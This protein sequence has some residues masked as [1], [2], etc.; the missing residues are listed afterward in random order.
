MVCG[1]WSSDGDVLIQSPWTRL[2]RL[3]TVGLLNPGL[4][5]FS[6]VVQP[7][8]SGSGSGSGSGGKNKKRNSRSEV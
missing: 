7:V 8:L 4:A 6:I 2:T 5:G 1:D 3:V